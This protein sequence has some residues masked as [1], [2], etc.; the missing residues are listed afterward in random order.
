M[1]HRIVDS[2]S[3]GS[4]YRGGG[5]TAVGRFKWRTSGRQEDVFH[6][7][8]VLEPKGHSNAR[9]APHAVAVEGKPGRLR[10]F[11]PLGKDICGSSDRPEV[12]PPVAQLRDVD[13]GKAPGRETRGGSAGVMQANRCTP[14]AR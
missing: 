4:C 14:E 9:I 3:C 2:A 11:H 13:A 5:S 6:S 1:R 10:R 7:A 8:G 12:P